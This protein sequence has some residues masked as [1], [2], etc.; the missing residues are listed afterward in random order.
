MIYKGIFA[1]FRSIENLSKFSPLIRFYIYNRQLLDQACT[2]HGK[3]T[4]EGCVAQWVNSSS[5]PANCWKWKY[6]YLLLSAHSQCKGSYMPINKMLIRNIFSSMLSNMSQPGGALQYQHPK[7]KRVGPSPL[8]APCHVGF[9][10]LCCDRLMMNII[11]N[12]YPNY[13]SG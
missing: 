2:I 5:C 11:V 7:Y 9:W 1:S 6:V 10:Y 4:C 3:S 8:L 13:W 12:D